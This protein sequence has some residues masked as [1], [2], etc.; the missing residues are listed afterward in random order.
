MLARALEGEFAHAESSKS[1]LKAEDPATEPES[2]EQSQEQ[3]KNGAYL[4]D[5]EWE[6]CIDLIHNLCTFNPEDRLTAMDALHHP[7]IKLAK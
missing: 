3:N 4:K 5:S 1:P 2:S 7:F 6:L